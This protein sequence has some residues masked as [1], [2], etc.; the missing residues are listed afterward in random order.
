[1]RCHFEIR[2]RSSEVRLRS[3]VYPQWL[4]KATVPRTIP[5]WNK[6]SSETVSA[7]S[8]I[9]FKSRLSANPWAD[10]VHPPTI[11]VLPHQRRPAFVR[12]WLTC[13]L[14]IQIQ[15][16]QSVLAPPVLRCEWTE[17]QSS[18]NSML[19][20]WARERVIKE[21]TGCGPKISPSFSKTRKIDEYYVTLCC[22]QQL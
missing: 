21:E 18:S 19:E 8:L 1:M 9:T 12:S 11:R 16:Q 6:L 10:L 15:I 7:D 4:W 3:S 22:H 14:S 17:E 2:L 20:L 5:E 13:G